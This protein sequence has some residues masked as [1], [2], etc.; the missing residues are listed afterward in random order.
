MRRT[1]RR[2]KPAD[3]YLK[4]I[5]TLRKYNPGLAT[6]ID[7]SKPVDWCIPNSIKTNLSIRQENGTLISSYDLKDPKKSSKM[8]A[9]T[10]PTRKADCT[11]LIGIGLGHLANQFLCRKEKEH[12]IIII[13]P[14]PYIIKLAFRI[15]DFSRWFDD[16]TLFITGHSIDEVQATIAIVDGMDV[17]ENWHMMA[18]VYTQMRPIEYEKT[19][20]GVSSLLNQIRC[21]TGTVMGAGKE[22]ALNDIK[23]FPYIIRHRGIKELENLYA[24]LP[25]VIVSTGPSLQKNIHI[26]KKMKDHV[27]IV[28][29]AQALRVLLAYDIRPDFICTVDYGKT[30][31][32]HFKGLMSS[33]VPLIALNR[34]YATVLKQWSGPKF[35]VGTP[36]PGHKHSASQ[37]IAEKGSVMCGGSVAHMA[38]GAASS[39]GCDPLILVGQDL[40]Y[41]G[42]LSHIETVDEGGSIQIKDGFIEWDV[43]DTRSHLKNESHGMGPVHEVP[44]YFGGTILTNLGLASFIT[45]FESMIKILSDRIIID[46]TE[47]G[48]LIEGSVLMSL[49]KA[50][51]K[52]TDCH[53][54]DNTID[55]EKMIEP[56]LSLVDNEEE[57]IERSLETFHNDLKI[58]NDI[59]DNCE[60]ALESA[61]AV[62][63]NI[64]D[65]EKVK[66]LLIKNEKPSIAAREAADKSPLVSV[67]IYNV[68]R[69]IQYN[70]M[71][72]NNKLEHL[73]KNEGDLKI[74]I[75]RNIMILTEARDVAKSLIEAYEEAGLLLTDYMEY[76]NDLYEVNPLIEKDSTCPS[77]KDAAELFKA[78]NWAKPLLDSRKLLEDPSVPEHTLSKIKG[79]YDKAVQ[80]RAAA[81]AI[82]EGLYKDNNTDIILE[83]NELIKK[84]REKGGTGN[85][86][87][88]LEY[89]KQAVNLRPEEEQARWGYA[90]TL[91][92]VKKIDESLEQYM[93]LRKRH[94]EKLVYKFEYANVLLVREPHKALKLFGEVYAKTEEFDWFLNRIAELYASV[95]L[96]KESMVAYKK[97]LEKYPG[98]YTAWDKLGDLQT[99]Q[100]HHT[101]ANRSKRKANK[102]RGL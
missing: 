56:Y 101:Q 70:N 52:Y 100:G 98:D 4:N 14:I 39:M 15:Y 97:Y 17:I 20:L 35:I 51:A 64:G 47:G 91:H 60:E 74:R 59:V 69:R 49:Q 22:I 48:A 18:E 65:T 24:D 42:N 28:A 66:G 92:H 55:K 76:I 82:S 16:S 45:Q 29:V 27:I 102:L 58:F 83:Y 36:V 86:K 30:N 19:L 80:L 81:Q 95:G 46:A 26:L 3:V 41:D 54:M 78:G 7:E 84:A 13:E 40:G 57:L 2:K 43:K 53:T 11:V 34:T 71:R 63:D 72:V 96:E 8:I 37:I 9:K 61:N 93:E 73:L 38:L 67:A 21:N 31:L 44:G 89:L 87:R 90:T 6:W 33:D 77:I 68:N 88:A 75:D 23:T 12:K 85:Y 99:K 32:G 79:V 5:N 25:A 10:L 94:P 1:S 50:M 62:K